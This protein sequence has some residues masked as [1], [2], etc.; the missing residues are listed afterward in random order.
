M[1]NFNVGDVVKL[2][3]DSPSMT[4]NK[5]FTKNIFECVWFVEGKLNKYKF[6]GNALLP[7]TQGNL[8]NNNPFLPKQ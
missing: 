6:S 3:S 2:K 7:D 8:A 5:K 1:N 4:I